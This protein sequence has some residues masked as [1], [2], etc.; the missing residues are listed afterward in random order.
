MLAG[1]DFE[2][3]DKVREKLLQ[4]LALHSFPPELSL[5]YTASLAEMPDVLAQH[6]KLRC[7]L[8]Y[9]T[10]EPSTPRLLRL[11]VC[12]AD[13]K[14]GRTQGCFWKIMADQV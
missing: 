11:P 4:A 6:G 7:L 8:L 9:L 12:S 2:A 10:H 3:H 14:L 13:V 1:Y 5:R